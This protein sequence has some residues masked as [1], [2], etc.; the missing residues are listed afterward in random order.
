MKIIV[1]NQLDDELFRKLK[2]AAA[3]EGRG[4]GEIVQAAVNDSKQ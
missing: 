2:V 1:G 3:Q 4:I